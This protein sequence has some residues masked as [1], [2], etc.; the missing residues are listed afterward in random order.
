MLA[1]A[2]IRSAVSLG[3]S[4]ALARSD[5]L[6]LAVRYAGAD[7]HYHGTA[8]VLAVLDAVD[9]LADELTIEDA[10]AAVIRAAA[11]AHDVIYEGSAGQDE[12]ASAAWARAALEAAGAD[13]AAAER[14]SELIL[15]TIRHEADAADSQAAI[16][17][18]A[19]LAVLGGDDVAYRNYVAAVRRDYSTVDEHDWRIGRSAVLTGLLSRASIYLTDPGRRRWEKLARIN[20]ATELAGLQP[21]PG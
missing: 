10:S 16:L 21:G 3:G 8:H 5:A 20:L 6:D 13:H 12:R 2:W 15:A 9:W 17:L 7:R 18:D 1:D 11:C 19:D 4:E 14:V